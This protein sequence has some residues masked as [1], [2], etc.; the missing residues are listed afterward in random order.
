M[1]DPRLIDH[2]G[3]RPQLG[4]GTFVAYTAR[5]IGDVVAGVDCSFWFG[6]VVRGDVFHIRIGDRVNL[7]DLTV[8]HVTTGKHATIIHDDVTV[9]HRAILHGCTIHQGAL[10]GMGATVMDEAVVGEGAMVAAGALVPPGMEIPPGMLAVGAP[11]RVR[12][13]LTDGER[14]WLTYSAAHYCDLAR[15]YLEQGCGTLETSS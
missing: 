4:A 15:T 5:I 3:A 6:T 11:A 10:V 14:G 12:R 13:E 1:N 2:H 9:G 7:Q 8:V